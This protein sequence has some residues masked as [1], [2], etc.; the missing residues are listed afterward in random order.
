M[1]DS[2]VPE[3]ADLSALS[4]AGVI[5][6]LLVRTIVWRTALV[7]SPTAMA[8]L[9]RRLAA[10]VTRWG[11]LSAKK[12]EAAIDELVDQIDP[13]ALRHSRSSGSQ[14]GAQFGSPGD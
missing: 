14:R 10:R 12:T 13:G 3:V 11:A 1:F 6:D 4:A 8:A 2:S 5:S 9:D 7:E